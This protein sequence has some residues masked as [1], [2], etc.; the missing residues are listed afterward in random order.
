[1]T[2]GDVERLVEEKNEKFSDD[3]FLSPYDGEVHRISNYSCSGSFT[4]SD[5]ENAPLTIFTTPFLS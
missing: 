4:E 3:E 2:T 1:M 5:N